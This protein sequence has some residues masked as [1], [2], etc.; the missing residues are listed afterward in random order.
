[1]AGILISLLAA[2]IIALLCGLFCHA[3]VKNARSANIRGVI[4]SVLVFNGLGYAAVGTL[5]PY[6][7]ISSL[8]VAAVSFPIVMLTGV[9]IQ[10]RRGEPV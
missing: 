5:D 4:Y 6:W 1:M 8:I 3:F 9:Y 7:Y 10:R 2:T